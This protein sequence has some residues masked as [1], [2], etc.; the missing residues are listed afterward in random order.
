[1]ASST[2]RPSWLMVTRCASTVRPA[3]NG[4]TVSSTGANDATDR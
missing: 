1:M 4:V 3:R 2:G